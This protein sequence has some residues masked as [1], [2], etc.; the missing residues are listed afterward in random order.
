MKTLIIIL[1]YTLM[2]IVTRAQLIDNKFNIYISSS[3]GNFMGAKTINEDNYITP[4]LY[5]NYKNFFGFSIKGMI[6]SREIISYGLNYDYQSANGWTLSNY[7]EFENSEIQLHTITPLIRIHNKFK[8]QGFFNKIQIYLEIGPT[9]GISNLTLSQTLFDVQSNDGSDFSYPM[10]D[11]NTFWGIKGTI[12][13]EYSFIQDFGLFFSYANNI[14]WI[15]SKLY[16][17]NTFSYSS[18]NV[19]L[20]VKFIKNKYFYY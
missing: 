2:S 14:N 19:G 9:I 17:D 12:G 15:S 1:T 4:S 16:N 3:L 7:T 18:I 11:S 10:K 13:V 6:N 5:S 20:I 8:E